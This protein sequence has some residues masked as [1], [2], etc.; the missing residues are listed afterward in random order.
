MNRLQK[1]LIVLFLIN[2]LVCL[3]VHPWHGTARN[4]RTEGGKY[5][6]GS[7]G[8]YWEVSR[9]TFTFCTVEEYVFPLSL[10]LLVSV[11][12]FARPREG[13]P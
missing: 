13:T 9:E 5:Y 4:G 6:L 2:V 1:T 12:L 7:K 3:L 11:F 8:N 10:L